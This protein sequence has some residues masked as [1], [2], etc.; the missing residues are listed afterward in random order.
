[1]RKGVAF[2]TR[3]NGLKLCQGRSEWMLLRIL[4]PGRVIR[5]WHRQPKKVV[6]PLSLDV[7]KRCVDVALRDLVEWWTW[8]TGLWGWTQASQ[9]S[10]PC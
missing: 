9:R 4:F 7:I 6:E 8:Q 3:G 5:H 2:R 10:L 1:M